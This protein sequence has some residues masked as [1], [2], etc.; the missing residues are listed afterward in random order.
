MQWNKEENAGFSTGKPWLKS[1]YSDIN[2]EEE[3][4]K[5]RNPH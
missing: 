4:E 2:V 1:N 3:Q 5:T